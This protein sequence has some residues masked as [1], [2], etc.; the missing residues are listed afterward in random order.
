M[1]TI[2][3]NVYDLLS[4]NQYTDWLGFGAYHTGVEV[5]GQEFAFGGGA[6]EGTGVFI[7]PP[8]SPRLMVYKTS[9]AIAETELTQYQIHERLMRLAREY[10]SASYHILNRNCNHFTHDLLMVLCNK[11]LPGWLN[12]AAFLAGFVPCLLPPELLEPPTAAAGDNVDQA[13]SVCCAR[14]SAELASHGL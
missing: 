13:T 6:A 12:R 7:M 14:P 11:P 1:P 4:S 2:Y 3:V 10:T 5:Y 8:R 9:I